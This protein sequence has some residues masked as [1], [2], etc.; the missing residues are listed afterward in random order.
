[1][2]LKFIGEVSPSD[3]IKM[4]EVLEN[5]AERAEEFEISTTGIGFFPRGEKKIIWIGLEPNKQLRY[6]HRILEDNLDIKGFSRK[7]ESFRPH[8]TLG[9]EVVSGKDFDMIKKELQIQPVRFKVDN[10]S[11]MESARQDGKLTYL[12]IN[13]KK[14]IK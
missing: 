9:R 4:N 10:I 12:P 6:L 5:T 2:T 14:L 3:I 8:I 13:S 7:E 1:M 11:L